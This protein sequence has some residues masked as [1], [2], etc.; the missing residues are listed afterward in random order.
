MVSKP[1]ISFDLHASSTPSAF[2]LNQDQILTEKTLENLSM[3]LV[4]T[5]NCATL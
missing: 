1:T 2:N 3:F 4:V 5:A